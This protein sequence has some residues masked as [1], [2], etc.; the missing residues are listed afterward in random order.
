METVKTGVFPGVREHTRV[1]T[2]STEVCETTLPSGHLKI[3]ADPW[4]VHLQ[5]RTLMHAGDFE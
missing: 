5:E 1:N 4:K 3:R 2:Q